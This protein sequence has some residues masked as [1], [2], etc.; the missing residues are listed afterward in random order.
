MNPSEELDNLIATHPDWRGALLAKLRETILA[1]DPEIVETWKWMG[2]PVWEQGGILCVGNIFTN[3][4][5]LTFQDGAALPDPDS[6]FNA[7]LEGNQR[8]AIDFFD[9]DQ[10]DT[11]A[12]QSLIRAAISFN[13]AKAAAKAM[14]K[15]A[16]KVA[17]KR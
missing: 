15:A 5:K 6:L 12:L 4:V 3:K 9:N 1:V 17:A 16:A 2:S 13:H 8:R 14:A 7:E 10:T 11:D